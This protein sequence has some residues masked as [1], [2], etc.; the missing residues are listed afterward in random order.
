MD[1]NKEIDELR[2]PATQVMSCIAIVII[3]FSGLTLFYGLEY[4]NIPLYLKIPTLIEILIII[5]SLLQFIRFINFKNSENPNKRLLKRYAQFLTIINILG[6]YNVAFAFNN[7]FYFVALQNFIDLYHFWLVSTLS[8]LVS[9]ILWTI[10]VI[11][12]FI[13]FPKWDKFMNGKKRTFIGIALT[14]IAQF[15]HIERIIE[16]ILAPNIADSKFIIA[17]M[18]FMLLGI[19]LVTFEWIRKYADFKILVLKE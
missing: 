1:F 4:K 12:M 2:K 8:I 17:G 19:Y 18:I 16:Y 10:G 3:T 7:V 13:E 6:S 11:L 14:F 5:L 9:F 15:I